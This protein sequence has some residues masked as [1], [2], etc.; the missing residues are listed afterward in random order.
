MLSWWNCEIRIWR[1]KK[2]RDATEKPKIVARIALEGEENITSATISKD[3]RLL[4]A[5]TASG[6]KLFQL[7]VP[8][9]DAGTGLRI[10]KLRS[11][12]IPGAKL[13]KFSADGKWLAIATYADQVLLART[14]LPTEG[15]GRP[16]VVPHILQ[17]HRLQRSSETC[18]ALNGSWGSYNRSIIHA[19]FSDDGTALAVADIA[20]YIDTWVIEGYEDST[21][22]EVDEAGSLASLRDDDESDM[23]DDDQ[24]RR[25]TI[26]GQRWV[27]NPSGHLLPKVDS[28]PLLI[29]FEPVLED[30][31]PQPNGN[32]AVHPTRGN[33]HPH[34][35]DIVATEQR[36]FV[37]T[38]QHSLYEFE[39][40]AGRLSEWSRRNP[41]ISYPE[42]FRLVDTPAK[43]CVWDVTSQ[44]KRV[45]L[46]G[47][48]WLFMFD[49]SQDFPFPGSSGDWAQSKKRKREFGANDTPRR[50]HSGAGGAVPEKEAPVTKMRK[51]VNGKSDE[52]H[53]QKWVDLDA[54]LGAETEERREDDEQALATLRRAAGTGGG[55]SQAN[56]E[57][58]TPGRGAPPDKLQ[59]DESKENADARAT[60]WYT[61]K[62]RPILGIVAISEG[63][64]P[65]EVVLVE[66]PKWE[67]EL[68]P[69]FVGTHE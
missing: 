2:Q 50:G 69:R 34:S 45:W 14:V 13:V 8:R 25:V 52:A 48:Q 56:G 16:R 40:L 63:T 1:V 11:P 60:W 20:G 58:H 39:M 9:L 53:G 44:H 10:R 61:F 68:P 19:D 47:E 26:F 22:P 59:G 65:L 29:S 33:P 12:T 43:G 62:Y 54:G 46:Y 5:A 49:L 37:V 55:R 67:L 28:T 24:R 7:S 57:K 6:V 3:G 27:P 31:R 38:A 64:Q 21:V 66:R 23:E 32:P 30:S 41:S 15:E 18:D 4:A 42:Q 35:R 51:L 17:L 36:I